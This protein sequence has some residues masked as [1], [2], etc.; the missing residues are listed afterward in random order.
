MPRIKKSRGRKNL[1]RQEDVSKISPSKP[2]SKPVSKLYSK[3][4]NSQ[5]ENGNSDWALRGGAPNFGC[6]LGKEEAKHADRKKNHG[7]CQSRGRAA[8]QPA[9]MPRGRP[10]AGPPGLLDSTRRPKPGWRSGSGKNSGFPK[11]IPHQSN[12]F[13]R[14]AKGTFWGFFLEALCPR[15]SQELQY[16]LVFYN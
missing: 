11:I 4:R 3:R 5:K 14:T 16:E 12:A 15:L 1:S 9:R 7:G 13:T 10:A 8:S 2:S 6:L